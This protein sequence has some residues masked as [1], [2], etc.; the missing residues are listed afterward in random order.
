MPVASL[1]MDL[2]AVVAVSLIVAMAGMLV[3]RGTRK[4]P[5]DHDEDDIG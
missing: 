3:Y 1:L 4:R 2:V 5:Q